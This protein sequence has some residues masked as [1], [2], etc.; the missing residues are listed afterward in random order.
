MEAPPRENEVSFFPSEYHHARILYQQDSDPG[1]VT[2]SNIP[3]V[4]D[5]NTRKQSQNSYLVNGEN[6]LS[7]ENNL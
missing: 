3:K 6:Y 4:N 5:K 7:F 2:M 1:E